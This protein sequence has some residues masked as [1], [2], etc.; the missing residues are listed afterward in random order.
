MLLVGFQ[1]T[2]AISRRYPRGIDCDL[3]WTWHQCLP[4]DAG[5]TAKMFFAVALPSS[6]GSSL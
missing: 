1:P 6:L 5:K 2:L 4:K 3:L